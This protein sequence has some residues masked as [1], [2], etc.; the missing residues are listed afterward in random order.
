MPKKGVLSY[1]IVNSEYLFIKN[2]AKT[3]NLIYEALCLFNLTEAL[4]VLAEKKWQLIKVLRKSFWKK[5][6]A[7]RIPK[8][9]RLNTSAVIKNLSYQISKYFNIS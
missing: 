6:K 3:E 8:E 4:Q 5:Q 9:A 2:D 1:F 7:T